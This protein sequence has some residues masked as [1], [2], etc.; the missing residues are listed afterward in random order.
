MFNKLAPTLYRGRPSSYHYTKALA[1]NLVAREVENGFTWTDPETGAT[2]QRPFPAAIVRPS[3]IT[4]AWKDPFPGW[5]DN[6][7]GTSGFMVV[8][9]KGVL[10]SVHCYNSYKCDMI[11]VDLVINTCIGSAWYVATGCWD[12]NR[13]LL[14]LNT[15]LGVESGRGS[16]RSISGQ[17][18]QVN[19]KQAL[20]SIEEETEE[21]RRAKSKLLGEKQTLKRSRNV[22]VVNCCSGKK[23]L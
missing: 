16:S 15:D 22:F 19:A 9:G 4:A 21:R 13:I 3:I 12:K 1:E 6:Y 17:G 7:Y 11:P 5:I 14:D 10:R 8:C 2:H 20:A 18:L 23:K